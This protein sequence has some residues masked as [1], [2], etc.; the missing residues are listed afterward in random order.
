MISCSL[1]CLLFALAQTEQTRE[2][3]TSRRTKNNV[4]SGILIVGGRK[5]ASSESHSLL[6]HSSKSAIEGA[7][8]HALLTLPRGLAGYPRRESLA[9]QKVRRHRTHHTSRILYQN[10][11][12]VLT[13]ILKRLLTYDGKCT[14]YNTGGQPQLPRGFWPFS[15]SQV[16]SSKKNL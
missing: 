2:S 1:S 12:V 15:G 11:D 3:S 14:L 8:N 13:Q 5:R 10:L 4:V 6:K 9:L 7:W 16:L